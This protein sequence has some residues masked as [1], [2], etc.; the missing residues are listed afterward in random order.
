MTNPIE[1]VDV[2]VHRPA[3]VRRAGQVWVIVLAGGSGTRL[4]EL[5][6]DESGLAV[7]KQFCCFDGRR[8]LLRATLD[9]AGRLAPA[10]RQ[11]VVVAGEHARWWAGELAHLPAANV[12]VQPVPRGTAAGLLLPVL[13]VLRQDPDAQLVILPSDHHVADEDLMARSLRAA[14]A[15]SRLHGGCPVLLG[16]QPDRPDCGYGW[17]VPGPELEAARR[18]RAFVEK[19]DRARAVTL[20][21]QGAVWSSF[22]L[23]SAGPALLRCYD[24]ALPALLAAFRAGLPLQA[25][26][27][28]EA[29]RSLY[30]RLPSRDFSRHVLE[31]CADEA[32]VLPV[33]WC[34]WSDLGT[35]DRVAACAGLHG[36]I[37]QRARRCAAGARG[38][39]LA[40]A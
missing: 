18:I 24:R 38:G 34:G 26:C 17:I 27:S 22:M 15:A 37:V 12:L 8:S 3:E 23:T 21:E 7:P 35:P 33:P 2:T 40:L 36:P 4:Q 1:R 9:R 19:P 29:L 14:G 30:E 31:A 5:T 13:H 25:P 16:M 39:E 32:R 11:V 20:L 28:G 6:R 10:A